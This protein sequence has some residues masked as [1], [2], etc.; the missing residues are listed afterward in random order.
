MMR[1]DKREMWRI[2]IKTILSVDNLGK[3][4]ILTFDKQQGILFG[5]KFE[6]DSEDLTF[7]SKHNRLNTY[8]ICKR[9]NTDDHLMCLHFNLVLC[10]MCVVK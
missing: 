1:W 2:V 3:C 9:T 5:G 10:W 6:L 8:L 4:L 7:G